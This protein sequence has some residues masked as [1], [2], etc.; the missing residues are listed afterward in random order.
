RRLPLRHARI[1]AFGMT[2][3]KGVRPAEDTCLK[4]LLDSEAPVITLVG[5]TWDM[6]VREVLG[7][8]LD[9][10]LR[11]IAD[12]VAYLKEHGREVFYDAEPFFDG[13]R[14]TPSTPCA[15]CGRLRKA[16]P[17]CSSCA[18]PTA[19]PCPTPSPPRWSRYGGRCARTSASTATTTATWPWPTPWPR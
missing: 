6:Q 19:A 8:T 16:A 11:M 1:A 4:A 15:R 10:N 12:S 9:E 18:T 14:H 3:R 17:R 5:K 13:F 2:R 7:T